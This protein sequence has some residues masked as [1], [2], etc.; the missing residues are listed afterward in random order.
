MQTLFCYIEV[1]N[2]QYKFVL[3]YDV[4]LNILPMYT[5]SLK[6]DIKKPKGM[7]TDNFAEEKS[8]K[9]F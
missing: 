5:G 3:F 8:S 2:I 9:N 6:L 7:D 1:Y 4:V